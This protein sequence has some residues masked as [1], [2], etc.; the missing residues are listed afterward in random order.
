MI[1]GLILTFFLLFIGEY[2]FITTAAVT[3]YNMHYIAQSNL[4]LIFG[5]FYR[6]TNAP[7]LVSLPLFI[8]SGYLLSETKAPTRLINFTDALIGWLPGGH[9]LVII[10]SYAVFTPLTGASGITVVALG[11]VLYPALME[12]KY[13]ERFI[14]G[15]I[16]AAGILGIMLPP[17][18][19][20]IIYGMVTATDVKLLFLGGLLPSLLMICSFLLY[21]FLA[22][23]TNIQ[24]KKFS[25]K[26]LFQSTKEIIWELP[27]PFITIG[28]IY[29]GI[30]TVAEASAIMCIY[31]FI[32]EVFIIK[33]I[34]LSDLPRIIRDSMVMVGSI[35]MIL[36][37]ALALTNFLVDQEVPMKFFN[38]IRQHFS[39][40]YSFLLT[41][42]LFLLVVG[43]TMDIFSA[44][45]VVMPIIK[46]V[47]LAFGIDPILTGV[48][49]ITN[50][51]IGY[52]T[53]PVG[54]DLF[55]AQLRFNKPYAQ[56]VRAVIPFLFISLLTLL[57]IT[58]VPQIS[59]LIVNHN[60]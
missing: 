59:T 48:I 26:R 43:C 29:S 14:L 27:I 35:I 55:L 44:I 21:S 2:L 53:P 19:P 1:F 54:V 51:S 12:M 17:S 16:T 52:I 23:K 31:L 28:G 5:E 15:L 40:K 33:D 58:Y 7:L 39:S 9:L 6:L 50:L 37:M 42:N 25:F 18:L 13:S 56:I 20:V 32:V 60:H 30:F 34:K 49:F 36:G 4:G 24:A 41:M 45:M 57:L 10:F 3:I 38:F 11:G 47:A 46:P 22:G 8:F